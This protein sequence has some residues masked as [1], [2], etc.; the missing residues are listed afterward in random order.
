[1]LAFRVVQRS[2]SRRCE[3]AG[4]VYIN[5]TIHLRGILSRTSR[6]E[7]SN[8]QRNNPPSGV[9]RGQRSTRKGPQQKNDASLE[10]QRFQDKKKNG[11]VAMVRSVSIAYY[12]SSMELE[13]PILCTGPRQESNNN[14]YY[15]YN[16]G[17]CTH[18]R[19]SSHE[20]MSRGIGLSCFSHS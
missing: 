3:A 20:D 19:K 16:K 13:Q 18:V 10:R 14:Y 11:S 5:A 1:M 9:P 6:V 4:S 7:G 2:E 8:P 15:N 12:C 17:R